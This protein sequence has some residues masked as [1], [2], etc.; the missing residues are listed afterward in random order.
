MAQG[1]ICYSR[2]D[3]AFAQKLHTVLKHEGYDVWVDWEKVQP[4]T[5]WR[6]P[7]QAGI[8]AAEIC[9]VILSPD[10]LASPSCAVEINYAISY[11]KPL[12]LILW[13]RV[14]VLPAYFATSEQILFYEESDFEQSLHQVMRSLVQLP[15]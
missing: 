14:S 6:E 2:K 5:D 10:L 3:A 11:N 15:G 8:Q 12:L 1:F 4:G 13:R 9:I 7:V